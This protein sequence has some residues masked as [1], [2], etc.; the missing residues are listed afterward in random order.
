MRTFPATAVKP[1][2]CSYNNQQFC[3]NTLTELLQA[4]KP[5][6][7][8]KA[9]PPASTGTFGFGGSGWG[10]FVYKPATSSFGGLSNTNNNNN[11]NSFGGMLNTNNTNNAN[12]AGNG[13]NT[14][15]QNAE[16]E[17]QKAQ[18]LLKAIDSQISVSK[19]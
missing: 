7:Y 12:N 1:Y 11:N 3:G 6:V 8:S 2:T 17:K 15:N 13:Q 19:E 10:V 5:A 16:E 14:T 4:V 9:N 18:A